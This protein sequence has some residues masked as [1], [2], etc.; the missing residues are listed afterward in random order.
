MSMNSDCKGHIAYLEDDPLQSARVSS[1]LVDHGYQCQIY[2]DAESI[3]TAFDSQEF[4]AALLDWHLDTGGSG[5]DVLAHLRASQSS[6]LPIVFLSSKSTAEDIA[7]VFQSGAN[8]FLAKPVAKNCLLN[9]L[10]AYLQSRHVQADVINYAPYKN[11]TVNRQWFLKDDL[12]ELTESD[13]ALT[14]YLFEHIGQAVSIKSL[15]DIVS[16]TLAESEDMRIESIILKLKRKLRMTETAR[17]KLE[18]IYD[19][20]YR[21]TCIDD[22][23]LAA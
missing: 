6:D 8:D 2:S 15:Q 19:Y 23:L 9:T 7:T 18:S 1:W 21:L 17:W 13:Y 4:D 3:Q 22:V 11:D 20:G 12:V 16:I 10:D 5:L 14:S